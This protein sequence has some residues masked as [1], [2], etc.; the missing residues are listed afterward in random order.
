MASKYFTTTIL[1]SGKKYITIN[2]KHTNPPPAE[3]QA[4]QMYVNAGYDIRFKSEA[5][6]KAARK[7]AKVHGFGRNKADKD[8]K[9]E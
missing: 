2:P 5:R 3:L 4:A 6:A 7:N 8:N 9:Q 1:A